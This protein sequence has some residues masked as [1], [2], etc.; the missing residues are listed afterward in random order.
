MPEIDWLVRSGGLGWRT[1]PT[2]ALAEEAPKDLQSGQVPDAAAYNALQNHSGLF[3]SLAHT[4]ATRNGVDTFFSHFAEREWGRRWAWSAQPWRLRELLCGPTTSL[5]DWIRAA[6]EVGRLVDLWNSIRAGD[7]SSLREHIL[8]RGGED[9]PQ[10]LYDSREWTK[11]RRERYDQASKPEVIASPQVR[12]E[13]LA[14]FEPND[15]VLPA[16]AYLQARLNERLAGKVHPRVLY[17]SEEKRLRVRPVPDDLL[18]ALWLQFAQAVEGDKKYQRCLECGAYFEVS[19][20]VARKDRVFCSNACRSKM[21]RDRQARAHD[22]HAAH[23]PL[24]QIAERL[25]TNIETVRGWLAGKGKRKG[26]PRRG[27]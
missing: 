3:M 27:K 26:R 7:P 25:D 15:V 5:D 21:Y 14:V 23:L 10:V 22:M 19:P 8:W 12:P 13:W 18:T 4:E 24:D 11:P 6:H 17:D 1:A 20:E 2:F 9:G 16:I